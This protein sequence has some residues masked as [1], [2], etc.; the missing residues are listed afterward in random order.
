MAT[1]ALPIF[2]T[3]VLWWLSTGVILYLDRLDRRTFIWSMAGATALLTISLWGAASASANANASGA[4][5][6]FAC[7][8]LVWG[9]QLVSFYMGYLTGPRKTACEPD[10]TGWRRFVEA[11]RTS[12]YHELAVCAFGVVLAA[13]TWGRPN[14]MALWTFLVLWWMHQSAKLNVYFG[15]PNLGEELLPDHLR[16]LLSFM[17]RK[18]MNLLFPFSVTISTIVTFMLAQKAASPGANPFE[19]AGL[20]MLA[21]LMALAVLEHWFLVTP[22]QTNAIWQWATKAPPNGGLTAQSPPAAQAHEGSSALPEGGAAALE[23]WTSEMP[24]LCDQGGLRRVL[25]SVG[26][27]IFGEVESLKGVVQ[28]S[29]SWIRFEVAGA[30]ASIAPFAPHRR[31]EPS[32]IAVGRQVDRAGLKAALDACSASG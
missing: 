10:C 13:L 3:L 7:G 16:Y 28:T 17:A 32:V 23:S 26:S 2:Y 22:L 15:V 5:L 14:R 9:W 31:P 4:Y 21:T 19:A 29:A 12:L 1:Y 8:L 20:T 11:V 25:D 24:G 6:A 18:P 27:G 30:R